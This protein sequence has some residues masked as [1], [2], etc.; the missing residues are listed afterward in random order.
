MKRILPAIICLVL[1]GMANQPAD[2]PGGNGSAKPESAPKGWS[3]AA[4]REEIRPDFSFDPK[5]GRDG[6]GSF[7]ISADQR[8]GLNGYWVRTV[9]IKGTHY[10]HF[11][12][13][14]KIENVPVPRRSAVVRVLWQDDGG[15][16]VS[17]DAPAAR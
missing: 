12:A 7:L 11:H 15:K 8:E 4:P 16:P 5:G 17:A 3:T 10:Y 2:Q 6:K 9:P 14:R 13:V 1:L